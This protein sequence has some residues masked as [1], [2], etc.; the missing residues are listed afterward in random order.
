MK[1]HFS[2]ALSKRV[3]PGFT[4]TELMVVVLIIVVLALVALYGV[5][6]IRDG[7]DK[8]VSARNL[9]QIQV[10]NMTYAT[11]HNGRFTPI[12]V[13]DDKGN[14]TRWF[15][16]VKFLANLLGMPVDD[17]D[18]KKIAPIPLQMLDPKVV[19]ARKTQYDR[20]FCSYGMNDTGLALGG[21][22]NL[23]S[24]HNLNKLAD[25]ARTMAFATATDFRVTYNNRFKWNFDNPNDSKTA[26]GEIAYR[27]S[28]K[29]L[30]VYFDGHCGEMGKADFEKIDTSGGKNNAFW[31]P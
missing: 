3:R 28:D 10:A 8:S 5:R 20:I 26:G 9:A 15:Q 24:G 27:H 31:K 11:E 4:L 7:A 2:K 30:V 17:L 22:P 19:R 23:D 21:E 1:T 6:R 12:R 13:N 14:P 18:P 16:D 25:P 29:V